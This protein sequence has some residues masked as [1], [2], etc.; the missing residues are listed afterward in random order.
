M[1]LRGLPTRRLAALGALLTTL[2]TQAP[3]LAEPE[4]LPIDGP[5]PP[6]PP[7]A[8]PAPPEGAPAIAM[9]VEEFRL[10]NG[11]HVILAPDATLPN[12]AIVVRYHAGMADEP[13]GLTG[14][15][16]LVE[17][18][19]YERTTHLPRGALL[20]YLSNAGSS[21][22]N[23]ITSQD[24]TVYFATVPA[25]RLE[26]A[27]WLESDR[28]G[29][30][31]G[32]VDDQALT[33][34]R[35][36][37]LTE[38]RTRVTDKPAAL[39]SMMLV[40]ST[41]PSWHPYH[42]AFDAEVADTRRMTMADVKAFYSTWY[43]PENATLVLAGK[44]DRDR[45]RALVDRYFGT[46]PG[47]PSP[48]RPALP[49]L[50]KKRETRVEIAANIS[51]Q[52]VRMSFITP[53]YGLPGDAELDWI[54]AMLS[55]GDA[56]LFRRALI[57]QG[58]A[59][60]ATARQDSRRLASV[61]TITAI[62]AKK[63]TAEDV[64]AAIDSVLTQLGASGP[65]AADVAR[66]ASVWEVNDIFTLETAMGRA[67]ILASAASRGPLPIPFDWR[68]HGGTFTP[69]QIRAVAARYL[70]PSARAAIVIERPKRDAP[71]AG[72]VVSREEP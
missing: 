6:A 69:T 39:S 36:V 64:T 20:R 57:D 4:P 11:L 18:L 17:H 15:A 66:A 71:L 59:L 3:A 48:R 47:R 1:S 19:T 51:D 43:G 21:D 56:S 50:E 10:K 7:L 14:I 5:S 30:F 9:P 60:G 26:L 8:A 40:E 65:S 28:M 24:K 63:R 33:Q 16:H 22:P 46:I 62:A 12:V 38:L 13:E 34:E 37:V 61:F 41:F 72:T 53:A 32:A 27:L 31:L 68:L 35:G 23:G 54:A 55:R 58:I 70:A 49:K 25:E 45:C 2:F 44:L 42:L 29:Y 67:S 52:G